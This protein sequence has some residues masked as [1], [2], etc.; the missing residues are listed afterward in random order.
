MTTP[1]TDAYVAAD[2][3][4]HR[5]SWLRYLVGRV[6]GS[7]ISNDDWLD[8]LATTIRETAEYREAMRAYEARR[9]APA[10]DD[11]YEAWLAAGPQLSSMGRA[12]AVMSSGEGRVLR[13]L[14][15]LATE[16]TS[17]WSVHDI[18]ALDQRGA[19]IVA[20]WLQIVR[21]QLPEW[22]YQTNSSR[23]GGGEPR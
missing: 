3:L 21:A 1:P 18:A 15:T 16:K 10:D 4:I 9:P 13:L 11:A 8:Q 20:D 23:A 14:A 2:W 22:L 19:R 7:T 12:Y 17:S 6:V 5:H